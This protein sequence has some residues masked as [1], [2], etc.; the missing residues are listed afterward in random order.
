MI[1]QHVPNR[2]S[3]GYITFQSKRQ[4]GARKVAPHN[5]HKHHMNFHALKGNA[6]RPASSATYAAQTL[7]SASYLSAETLA[8]KPQACSRTRASANCVDSRPKLHEPQDPLLIQTEI[9][10]R[11]FNVVRSTVAE[12]KCCGLRGRQ[13]C[14]SN[15]SLDPIASHV[16]A[17]ARGVVA[18]GMNRVTL[19]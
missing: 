17:S 5:G 9:K 2:C 16:E 13:T 4:P 10:N 11:L 6:A 1:L 14:P 18:Q 7:Q 3:C 19:P 8:W 15:P 12:I